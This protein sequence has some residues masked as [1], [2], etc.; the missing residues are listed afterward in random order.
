MKIRTITLFLH[1]KFDAAAL[2]WAGTVLAQACARFVD[3]G[4]EVQTRRIAL[5]HWDV[6]LGRN[7][8]AER[9]AAMKLIAEG[10][11][12]HKIDMCGI[13]AAR[14]PE[15]IDHLADILT[16]YPDFNGAA[17]GANDAGT[18]DTAAIFAAARA[19]KFLQAN[20]P[21][22]LGPFQFACGFHIRPET[23]F[24][25]VAQHRGDESFAI[26]FE[27]SDL[28]V[29]AFAGAPNLT[30]AT[31][32]LL[33]LFQQEHGAAMRIADGIAAE[34]GVRFA[35]ADHSIAP[36]LEPHESLA[37]AFESLDVRFG[38]RG[39]TAICGAM[40]DALAAAPGPRC[41]YNGLMLALL[42]DVGLAA[43]VT[44]GD[45][46]IDTLMIGSSVCGVGLDTVPVPGDITVEQL[47]A[48]Y[49]D[50]GTIACKWKKPLSVRLLPANGKQAGEMTEFQ[51]PHLCN[52]RVLAL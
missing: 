48:I 9:D 33:E 23:P 32:N 51:S 3:A 10:C 24:F 35:G 5:A 43:A 11:A 38:H 39:T 2:A 26:A 27:N 15:Q 18:L 29:K 20:T 6:G 13:G 37:L 22:G 46:T 30:V 42:E 31:N 47:A 21:S 40:T 34:I 14:E 36:S 49:R 45:C 28:V 17:D 19:V 16:R 12:A 44:C 50:V 25:P 7:N 8:V 41:G 4:Y 1:R 52:C